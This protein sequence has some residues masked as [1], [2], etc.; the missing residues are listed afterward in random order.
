LEYDEAKK[1]IRENLGKISSEEYRKKAKLKQFPDFLPNKPE[2]Q[3]ENFKWGEFLENNGRRKSKDF[4]LDYEEA[5][6]IVNQLN[7]K[8]NTE[9]RRWCKNKPEKFI[10]IPSS[11]DSVYSEWTDWY[12]WLG[13]RRLF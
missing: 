12:D 5:K 6:K 9:W 1:W 11:P 7:L 10:R 3:Y 4:Y 13:N 8:T 2:R